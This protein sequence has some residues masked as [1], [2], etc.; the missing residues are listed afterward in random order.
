[1]RT[2]VGVAMAALT[3]LAAVQAFAPRA[4]PP[5]AATRLAVNQIH[6]NSLV[7]SKVG[8][9][10]A[11]ELGH[12]LVSRD[13]GKTWQVAEQ[14]QQRQALINQVVFDQDG[15]TGMAV[16]HEGW[17]LGTHDGGL[18]WKEL[19]F[20]E[21]NGE[22]FMS[23][24]KLPFGR[25]IA[26]GAFRR[27]VQSDDG[28]KTWEPMALPD[29]GWEDKHLNRIVGSADGQ[30]WLIVGE[31]G[32]LLKSDNQGQD[33]AIVPEFYNGSFYNALELGSGGW[34]VYG[35]RGNVFTNAGDG[36]WVKANVPA[37]VSFYGHARTA[38]GRI[39]LVGQGSM[40]ASST[41]NGANFTLSRVQGRASLTDILLQADGSGWIASDAG[42]QE[43]KV[44][45]PAAPAAT[46]AT[47]GAAQ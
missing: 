41:D 45:A 17:I 29:M 33:W 4:T 12:I 10:A 38:D 27:A 3:A 32:L 26:V 25:W 37:P 9:V 34:M 44:A 47:A 36:A 28:G 1:M 11:G 23:V 6:L 14:S 39:M 18:T 20:Q 8:L 22:P 15:L 21:Q 46:S 2:A 40:L 5:L 16:G 24:A 19:A 31:R 13:N 30:R 7:Q 35:M 43:Y 42:L